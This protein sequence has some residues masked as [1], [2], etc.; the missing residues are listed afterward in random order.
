MIGE[1]FRLGIKEA[2]REWRFPSSISIGIASF[3]IHGD[4]MDALI[5]QAEAANKSA[6]EQGKDRVVIAETAVEYSR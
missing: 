1:R 2:S 3:P 5:D 4:T 6:K